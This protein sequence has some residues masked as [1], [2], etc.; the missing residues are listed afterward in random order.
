MAD[1]A[2]AA[3]HQHLLAGVVRAVGPGVARWRV[4]DEVYG[5]T[6]GVAGLQGSLAEYAAVDADL[7]ARKPA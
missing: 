1:T 3:V 5:L 2:R 4:G 7:L 6:G